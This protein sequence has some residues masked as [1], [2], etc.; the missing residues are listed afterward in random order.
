MSISVT[1]KNSD[2]FRGYRSGT[3][4]WNGLTAHFSF[5]DAKV[6]VL[7]ESPLSGKPF[8][9]LYRICLIS[10]YLWTKNYCLNINQVIW[11]SVSDISYNQQSRLVSAVIK[12]ISIFES[13]VSGLKSDKL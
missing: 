10:C 1:S 9:K 6:I 3:F 2:F 8:K 5:L 7:S 13:Y 11:A 12:L 4:D